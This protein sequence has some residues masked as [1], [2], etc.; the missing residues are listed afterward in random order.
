MSQAIIVTI[1]IGM[2]F[3]SGCTTTY[4]QE[5]QTTNVKYKTH[6]NQSYD[7]KNTHEKE[8]DYDYD[9]YETTY[10]LNEREEAFGKMAD[11]VIEQI[12][13]IIEETFYQM[14][15]DELDD[16]DI[17]EVKEQIAQIIQEKNK[18]EQI[19]RSRLK[20]KEDINK[21]IFDF[22]RNDNWNTKKQ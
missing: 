16:K 7:F 6:R 22:F 5:T 11:R 10:Y 3:L 17:E 18:T 9:D 1:I 20:N 13:P 15:Y 8:Y 14:A 12:Y 21:V 19:A 2:I 4:I